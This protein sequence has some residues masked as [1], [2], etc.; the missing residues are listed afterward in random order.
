MWC[1]IDRD[2]G[3]FISEHTSYAEAEQAKK[4][5]EEQAERGQRFAITYV[6]GSWGV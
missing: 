6:D 1:V 3:S 5:Y 2:I 4:E